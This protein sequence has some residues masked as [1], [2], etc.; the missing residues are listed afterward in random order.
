MR[1][2]Y[3]IGGSVVALATAVAAAPYFLDWNWVKPVIVGAAEDALGYELE[4]AGDVDF[5]LFP[6]PQLMAEGVT[7]R[8]FGAD[9][10][11]LIRADAL[12][13]AVA[14]W[15]LFRK[16][17][18]VQYITLDGPT[19][20]LAQY[21]DGTTNW[22]RPDM[23]EDG[24]AAGS[25]GGLKIDDFRISNGTLVQI[26]NGET[27]RRVEDVDI[28][29][30]VGGRDGPY[31]A[32]GSLIYDGLPVTLSARQDVD[33]R[34]TADLNI[35]EDAKLRFAGRLLEDGFAGTVKAEGARLRD[36]LARLS[37]DGEPSDAAAYA[38]GFSLSS[39]VRYAG[40]TLTLPDIEGVI[41]GTIIAGRADVV[42]GEMTRLRAQLALGDVD[43]AAWQ[44][45]GGDGDDAP[46]ELPRD[47]QARVMLSFASLSYGG[48]TFGQATMPLSLNDG[49]VK[50]G[51]TR[52]AL[53]GGGAVLV[54]GR[55]TDAG[56]TPTFA[57][58]MQAAVP[59]PAQTLA[60]FG[61]DNVVRMPAL[62]VKGDV[63]Y[64]GTGLALT[65]LEGVYDGRPF[66]GNVTMPAADAT[67]LSVTLRTPAF[68]YDRIKLREGDGGGSGDAAARPVA[69]DVNIGRLR[70]GGE[71]YSGVAARGV[72]RAEQ[73]QLAR[74]TVRDAAGFGLSAR[75]TIDDPGGR[76]DMALKVGLSGEDGAGGLDVTGP[77]SAFTVAG[78]MTFA[79]A[80]VAVNGE[81]K[82]VPDMLLALDIGAK[83]ADAG[84]VLA[85]LQDAPPTRRLGPLDIRM[86]LAGKGDNYRLSGLTGKVGPM[87]LTGSADI[88]AG[89]DV[90][91]VQAAFTAGI[92]P[93]DALMGADADGA[94]DAQQGG[95]R[96]SSEALDLGWIS[97]F[98]G[99][100]SLSG[101]RLDYGDYRLTKP[102][103]VMVSDGGALTIETLSGGMFGGSLSATG[104]VQSG[105]ENAIALKFAMKGV[106]LESFMEA[107][108]AAAPATGTLAM[109]GDVSATGASQRELMGGLKGPVRIEATNGV[110]RKIDLARL[111]QELGDLRSAA[112][113]LRLANGALA[114]GETRYRGIAAELIGANGRF[115]IQSVASDMDGGRAAGGGH[116]DI[117][118]WAVDMNADLML[119]SHADAPRI[120]VTIKGPLPTPDV[121][122]RLG[123][124]QGWFAK[125]AGL[126]ALN[127]V[128]GRGPDP[129]DGE[130]GGVGEG[131]A[132]APG[133][134]PPTP[135]TIEEELG[136]A[137]VRGLG[138]LLGGKKKED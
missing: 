106:P 76:N 117:G 73:V 12:G 114:G 41:A 19:V 101:E 20:R 51:R 6:R 81:V 24:E 66:R 99:R 93:L 83:A 130:G 21:A 67:A 91:R 15:P 127:A 22:E 3:I 16:D 124:L 56:G 87:R 31:G 33:G 11:P 47:M 53:P 27:V 102:E 96:W 88:A 132:L 116:V 54:E 94:A 82:T 7:V 128:L 77:L 45:S 36:V 110:I 17:I 65:N 52:M 133:E 113:F 26:A 129:A 39:G 1:K 84:A 61:M 35:E 89:G 60:A 137:V 13:A 100:I 64:G 9:A 23:P 97:S 42:P 4:V 74:A 131:E 107:S 90:P 37:P 58:V 62:S 25:G 92:I 29:L 28:R 125:R 79:G 115:Q 43:I 122:Y 108:T 72:Y 104:R 126:V 2:A 98:D 63:A 120:P 85:K 57:G 44:G 135:K 138:A 40:G 119:G 38:E 136:D 59:R 111:D 10:E 78:S 68:D 112:S 109:T 75:G 5:A 123:P 50:L 121:D 34:I 80:D 103:L 18:E 30:E 46:F 14:F 86:K 69:F 8:G 70:F 32:A 55:L 49:R 118:R 95:A 71:V 134:T 48:T 105:D